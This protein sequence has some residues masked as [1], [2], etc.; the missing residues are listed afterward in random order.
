MIELGILPRKFRNT[1]SKRK[2]YIEKFKTRHKRGHVWD[3]LTLIKECVFVMLCLSNFLSCVV[4]TVFEFTVFGMG[5]GKGPRPP[6]RIPSPPTAHLASFRP[7]GFDHTGCLS[8]T[9]QT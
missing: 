4:K 5:V 9:P 8:P 7:P 2:D 3:Y 1:G 6:G